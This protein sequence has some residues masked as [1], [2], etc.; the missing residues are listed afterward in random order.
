MECHVAAGLGR[1]ILVGSGRNDHPVCG[2]R[3]P[4]VLM[5]SGRCD[6]PGM[7]P[8]PDIQFEACCQGSLLMTLWYLSKVKTRLD[9]ARTVPF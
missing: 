7:V 5:G 8:Q 4:P 1:E 9:A 6:H 2:S 3:F